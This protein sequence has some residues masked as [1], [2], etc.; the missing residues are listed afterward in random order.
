MFRV[1]IAGV[2]RE[3]IRHLRS[4]LPSGI[5]VQATPLCRLLRLRSMSPDLVVCTRFLSHKHTLHLK[6]IVGAKIAYSPGGLGT[7]ANLI[8]DEFALRNSGVCLRFA[9]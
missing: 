1:I 3:Q 2:R 5:S 6:L 9:S 4:R 8:L 7:W